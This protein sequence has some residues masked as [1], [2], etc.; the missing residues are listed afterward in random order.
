MVGSRTIR[1]GG[2]ARGARGMRHTRRTFRPARNRARFAS[3]SPARRRITRRAY[4]ADVPPDSGSLHVY[5]EHD[6][7]PWIGFDRVSDDPIPRTPF[8][9]ELMAK[10]SGPRLFLDRPCY[11]DAREEPLC[12]P[13]VWTHG[14]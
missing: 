7:T 8:A 1:G 3:D 9:L 4:V 10:D 14:R 13:L 2:D 5:I 12:N 6:G 11:F